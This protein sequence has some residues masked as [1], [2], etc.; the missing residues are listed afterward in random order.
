MRAHNV[1]GITNTGITQEEATRPPRVFGVIFDQLGS[2]TAYR[3]LYLRQR[4]PVRGSLARGVQ[5]EAVLASPD[6][7][8]NSLK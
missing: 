3:G 4:N 6:C 2:K 8:L 1:R 5:R 7:L